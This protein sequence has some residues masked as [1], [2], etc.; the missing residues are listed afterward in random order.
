MKYSQ[1][2]NAMFL[3]TKINAVRK[4]VGNDTTN[5]LANNGKRETMFGCR[6]YATVNFS[7]KLKAQFLA[8]ISYLLRWIL[9]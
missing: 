4:T 7:H 2:N 6:R 1:D 3:R 8:F 5:V 9:R